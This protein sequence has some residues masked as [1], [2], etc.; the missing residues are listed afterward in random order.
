VRMMADDARSALEEL[1]KYKSVW[2]RAAGG[3]APPTEVNQNYI[4]LNNLSNALRAS[5]AFLGAGG[6]P[7]PFDRVG[8]GGVLLVPSRATVTRGE[9]SVHSFALSL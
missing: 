1:V 8:G 2:V 6:P 5:S 9:K 3:D 7:L 4:F